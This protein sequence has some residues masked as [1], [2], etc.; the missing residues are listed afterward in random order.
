MIRRIADEIL[1][2]GK[3]YDNLHDLT[4]NIGGRLSGSPQMYKAE[5]WGLKT[6]KLSG[7]DNAWMQEC[8]IPHW[9]RG[10]TDM[11]EANINKALKG[12]RNY[13]PGKKK[14]DVIALGNS[15]GTG[16]KG[17]DA[18]VMEVR[19][20]D[21]LETKKDEIKGKIVFYNYKFNPT[22]IGTFLSYGDAVQ[23][24]SSGPSHAAKYG[25]VAVIVR[26]MTH[27]TDNNPHTGALRYTDSLPKIPAVAIGLKDADW[28]D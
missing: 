14:L 12:N 16:P 17:I 19:S 23:Y 18:Y 10:G 28:L 22:F 21:D 8:M 1:L 25:A 11:A 3:A 9:I 7:A 13:I 20:F 4:K 2:N 27:S 24:R 6:M 26:S 5:E 15:V